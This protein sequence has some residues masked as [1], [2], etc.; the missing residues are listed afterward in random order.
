MA[1]GSSF[2]RVGAGRYCEARVPSSAFGARKL[3]FWAWLCDLERVTLPLRATSLGGH[4][5]RKE[6]VHVENP[7]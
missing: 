1:S 7:S 3:E 4:K 6:L 2:A 5:G